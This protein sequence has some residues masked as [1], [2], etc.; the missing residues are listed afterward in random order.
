MA[1]RRKGCLVPVVSA[2]FAGVVAPVLVNCVSHALEQGDARAEP[3]AT[4]RPDWTSRKPAWAPQK[5]VA[6]EGEQK[7]S[8]PKEP[9]VRIDWGRG[10]GK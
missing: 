5:P 4:I 6:A 2:V 7:P 1:A 9:G 10:S 3:P 8:R